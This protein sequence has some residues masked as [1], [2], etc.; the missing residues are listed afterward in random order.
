MLQGPAVLILIIA[1]GPDKGRI[2]ELLDGQE[3]TLGRDGDQVKLNDRK[4]SREHARL[5]SEGGQWY[6]EDLGSRHGTHRNHTQLEHKG[7]A[8]VKDGDF[9]QIGNTV[10]VLGRMPAEHAERLA[11]LGTNAAAPPSWRKPA[12]LVSAS[13]AAALALAGLGVYSVTLMQQMMD[14]SQRQDEQVNDL[15]KA[16]LDAQHENAQANREL[17]IAMAE[18]ANLDRDMLRQN[19]RLA[20]AMGAHELALT[21][22]TDRLNGMT[23][24]LADRLSAVEE[25]AKA[26][27]LAI[28]RVGE[29]LA[30][31][32]ANDNSDEVLALLGSLEA[33]FADQPNGQEM[34]ERLTTALSQNA[35]H[36]GEIVQRVMAE[37]AEADDTSQLAAAQR[38]EALVLRVLEELDNAP[39]SAQ[40]AAEVATML[41]DPQSAQEE[42]MR[43]VLVELRRTGDEISASVAS[44]INEDAGQAHNLMAQVMAELEKQPTGEQ[45]ASDLQVALSEAMTGQSENDAELA[46]LMQRVLA[47]LDQRPTTDTLTADL[48]SLVGDDAQ[49]TQQLLAQVLA[50]LDERPTAEQIA[51]QIRAADTD[52]ADQ[53][54]AMV[55]AVLARIEQQNDLAGEIASLRSAFEAQPDDNAE[56][57]TSIVERMD[58]QDANNAKLLESISLLRES[59]PPDVSGQLEEVLTQLDNQVREE[60]ITAAVESA[61]ERIAAS[62]D[63]EALA[64]IES[65]SERLAALPS[66][67]QLEE[68]VD[69]QESLSALLDQ[70]DARE[71]LGELRA[72]LDRLAQAQPESADETMA[73]LMEMLEQRERADL[74]L[75]EMHDLLTAQPEQAAAMREEVLAAVREAGQGNTDQLLQQLLNEVRQNLSTDEAIR[76]AIREEMNGTIRP[77]QMALQDGHNQSSNPT[78]PAPGLNPGATGTEETETGTRLTPLQRD[79]KEAFETGRPVTIGAGVIDPTTGQVSEGRRL[80]PSAARALGFDDWHDWYLT[81]MH[82]QRMRMQQDAQRQ[83]NE[84]QSET[85]DDILT[86]PGPQESGE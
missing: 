6:L 69:S 39:S 54:T 14:Q 15:G 42:F 20:D 59:M 68:V 56:L 38:T 2:Y 28:E 47:E 36:T 37:Q 1:G 72:A 7:K 9:L 24:P 58:A 80:D 35:E 12:V 83:R 22:A 64:A 86:L 63:Q 3:V 43:Q 21:L 46:Q 81:D 70:T 11:L 73:R 40:I 41:G 85:P 60:Q 30:H 61:V 45:L 49:Q 66:A 57:I 74:M 55:E 76:L 10:M 13:V 77:N 34:I 50:E 17:R 18:R 26:Q 44:A 52:T 82:A 4:V 19:V 5:W 23:G 33:S 51:Q 71:A 53:T 67:A 79:Y 8:K 32:Q 27:S 78:S 62:R 25:L 48:R 16:L 29:M 75:A 84:S 65:L 31:D